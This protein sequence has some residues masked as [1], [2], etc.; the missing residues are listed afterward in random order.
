MVS[1]FLASYLLPFQQSYQSYNTDGTSK[2]HFVIEHTLS[3]GVVASKQ[4]SRAQST[5]H[6]HPFSTFASHRRY[7]NVQMSCI[8]TMCHVLYCMTCIH[9]SIVS[10]G[11]IAARHA[12][13]ADVQVRVL[14]NTSRKGLLPLLEIEIR[15]GGAF[16]IQVLRYDKIRYDKISSNE[17]TL[18]SGF[19]LEICRSR[20]DVE[21]EWE[22]KWILNK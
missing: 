22:Q 18:L 20:R 2:S 21:V 10:W 16:R 11:Y 1:S 6:N 8:F 12:S 5:L 4:A 13:S 3:Y 7:T 9:A 15:Y 19:W 17:A 14:Q